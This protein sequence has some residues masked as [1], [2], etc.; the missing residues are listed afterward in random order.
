MMA[1]TPPTQLE[2]ATRFVEDDT[3]VKITC[4]GGAVLGTANLLMIGRQVG[5]AVSGAIAVPRYQ[6]G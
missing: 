3:D 6:L 1:A 2:A 5:V 4:N